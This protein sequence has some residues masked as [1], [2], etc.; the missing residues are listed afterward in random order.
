MIIVL[1]YY[2]GICDDSSWVGSVFD[3]IGN[4]NQIQIDELFQKES[5]IY[6]KIISEYF[7]ERD[8]YH[9]DFENNNP[10]PD[11]YVT[12]EDYRNWWAKS[13]EYVNS[14]MVKREIEEFKDWFCARNTEFTSIDFITNSII[15]NNLDDE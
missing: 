3:Y 1:N 10:C 6:N 13:I 8:K 12:E 15:M 14:Q 5:E 2:E 9:D 11:I 7:R 4:L